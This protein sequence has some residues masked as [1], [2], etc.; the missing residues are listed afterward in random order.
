LDYLWDWFREI[1]FGLAPNGFAPPVITWE[2][3]RSWQSM[4][5]VGELEPWEA[6]TLIQLGVLRAS[7]Q[8]EKSEAENRRSRP[9]A[10]Q[11]R[12]GGG[13]GAGTSPGRELSLPRR[14]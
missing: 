1:S 8:A 10:P 7:V 12:F 5:D 4:M 3:L 9:S 14:R 13:A 11:P 2:A 6:R